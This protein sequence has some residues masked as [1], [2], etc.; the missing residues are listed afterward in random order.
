[1]T[2]SKLRATILTECQGEEIT[3]LEI[4]IETTEVRIQNIVCTHTTADGWNTCSHTKVCKHV[5][6]SSCL[7]IS[8]AFHHVL[9]NHC[10]AEFLT[11]HEVNLVVFTK[12]LI[13]RDI[14]ALTHG[15]L[16]LLGPF[17]QWQ[18]TFVRSIGSS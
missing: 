4:I 7:R 1:M 8:C 3:L 14:H 6:W 10:L 11:N 15:A 18:T 17:S 5:V 2:V 12:L 16:V 9:V 13:V